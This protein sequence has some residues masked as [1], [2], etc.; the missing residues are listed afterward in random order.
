TRSCTCPSSPS[1]PTQ[2]WGLDG[3]P[4]PPPPRP[5]HTRQGG[6]RSSSGSGGVSD[7]SD[8]SRGRP[9]PPARPGL[10]P[11]SLADLFAAFRCALKSTPNA[12][13][14]RAKPSLFRACSWAERAARSSTT[15]VL[16]AFA[17][18]ASPSQSSRTPFASDLFALRSSSSR[19]TATTFAV[20][21]HVL[22]STPLSTC[23]QTSAS[24][25]DLPPQAS[26]TSSRQ[27][28]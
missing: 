9:F 13:Q 25:I 10:V 18:G 3:S 8:T 28:S 14:A 11:A 19:R 27:A 17:P 22:S 2:T 21:S 24:P 1:P 4:P 26:E 6:P 20:S 15:R 12:W 23:P 16:V 5:P 7:R